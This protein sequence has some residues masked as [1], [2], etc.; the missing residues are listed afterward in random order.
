MQRAFWTAVFSCCAFSQN[1]PDYGGGPDSSKHVA[2]SQI[3]KAN[4]G[5][6]RQAS[7]YPTRDSN[8][9]HFNPVVID[10]VMYTLARNNSLVALNAA[11]GG[12]IWVHENP[13][14]ELGPTAANPS[15]GW[16][17]V[18]TRDWPSIYRLS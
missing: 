5:K 6:L 7:V 15:K 2:L 16:V 12:E 3:T 4:V 13:G 17:Y 18:L 9:Y 8:S 1:W 14:A 11:T 10:G